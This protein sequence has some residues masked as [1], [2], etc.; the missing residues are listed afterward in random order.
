MTDQQASDTLDIAVIGTGISGLSAAW[1]L[2]RRH[3]VTVYESNARPGG[4]SHTIDA[5]VV[6]PTA[7]G[8]NG[9]T[10]AIPV[11]IGFIVYN[12]HTYPNLTA[13][14]RHLDVPT[15]ASDMSFGV[16]LD[17]G[18]LEYAGTNLAGL[19]AQPFNLGRPRFWSMLSDLRRFYRDAPAQIA[20]AGPDIGIG[21]FL[22]QHGYGTAFQQDHILPMAAA[23]WSASPLRLRDYPASGFI[24]FFENHGLLRFSDRPQWRTVVGGS[25]TYVDRLTAAFADGLRLDC[26][27]RFVRRLPAGTPGRTPATTSGG[28]SGK[29][30]TGV[31]IGDSD[32]DQ[33][34]F[35]HVVI[36][37][38]ANQALDLLVD[39]TNAE[40]AL[41]GAFHYTA[42]TVILHN[43]PGFMPRRKRAWSSW[44]YLGRRDEPEALSVTYWMNRL[45]GIPD[46]SP[47]FVT[48]NP[49]REAEPG[50]VFHHQD[51][52]HPLFDPAAMRAQ[53]SL[54]S[55]QGG[56]NTWYCGAYFGAGFHE[57]GLQAGLAV[58]EQLGGVRRPWTVPNES[59]RI[60]VAAEPV[61]R[62]VAA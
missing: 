48:L 14:F 8:P 54:W 40:R 22:N 2:S 26:S 13:L 28:I 49:R 1:L 59:G 42:N 16:S 46:S 43:D 11:D 19:F 35:D 60:H 25:R 45:Q 3:R 51:C 47:L 30:S 55:L 39:P 33:R 62:L 18:A 50:S 56:R 58:A 36:A 15:R 12:E 7:E 31:I 24:R 57:D 27:A 61:R 37:C 9:R 38:H 32:G 23:I 41:L 53:R 6:G 10:D 21:D 52:T 17:D 5:P 20:S 44:N 29:G 4:H 34:R